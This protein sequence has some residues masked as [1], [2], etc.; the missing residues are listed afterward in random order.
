MPK[1]TETRHRFC[2]MQARQEVQRL[3]TPSLHFNFL[4]VTCFFRL[5]DG[6][7]RKQD[8]PMKKDV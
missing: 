3:I 4:Y 8:C 5:Y 2:S 6:K 7:S 1:P